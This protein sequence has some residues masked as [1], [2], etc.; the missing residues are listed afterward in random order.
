[1]LPSPAATPRHSPARHAVRRPPPRRPGR[2]D[3]R[4][5]SLTGSPS[6]RATATAPKILIVHGC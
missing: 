4:L 6:E 3:L 5:G 2:P 1:M